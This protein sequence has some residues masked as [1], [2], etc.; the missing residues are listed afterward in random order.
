MIQKESK[1]KNK[2]KMRMGIKCKIFFKQFFS[3]FNTVQIAC[4]FEKFPK[5]SSNLE[6]YVRIYRSEYKLKFIRH[7]H[8][9]NGIYVCYAK[10][11]CER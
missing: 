4:H 7:L 2:T 1:K 3:I 8:I 6:N 9:L 11:C 5:S 10:I